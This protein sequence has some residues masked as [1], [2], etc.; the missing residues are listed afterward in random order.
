MSGRNYL[1]WLA[2][3]TS[4]AWWHD[5]G[6][7][8][9]LERALANG[10][11]GVTTN[12]VLAATAIR[13]NREAWRDA[14]RAAVDGSRTPG[15]K[16]EALM[17]IVV[18]EAAKRLEPTWRSTA[19]VQGYVC[20]QVNPSL[21]GDRTAM[22]DMARRLDVWAPNIAVKLPATAAGLDVMER[23]VADGITTTITL[24]F[25]VAQ[26][27]AAGRRFQEAASRR[28]PG[29]RNGR[30]FAVIMI[31]RLDEYLREVCADN[32]DGLGDEDLKWAGLAVVKRALGVYRERGYGAT[33]MVAAL[34]GTYHMTNLAGGGLVMSIHPTC[35]A[36]L[37]EGSVQRALR[38]DEPVPAGVLANLER[39]PEFAKAYEPEGLSEKQMVSYGVTQRT[40]SQFIESGWKL[41]EQFA[42]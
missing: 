26:V 7:P 5:S 35:Q 24:G 31:G 16:A 42:P 18:T 37:L 14:I 6:D 9:E 32:G 23:L 17:R 2:A 1:Q 4:T 25:T 11:V 20:A 15:A 33:L 28:R 27:L 41:L 19:G 36:A 30:A 39:V 40:V 3:E 29:A 10:A 38:V 21:A 12:P 13:A 8:A 34:R 22:E